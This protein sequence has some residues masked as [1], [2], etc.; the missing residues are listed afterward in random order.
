MFFLNSY[1]FMFMFCNIFYYVVYILLYLF[2]IA[3]FQNP[4]VHLEVLK[5]HF[6]L[7]LGFFVFHQNLFYNYGYAFSSFFF[8]SYFLFF[9]VTFFFGI[10]FI[11]ICFFLFIYR[12]LCK[13]GYDVC[14]LNNFC[15]YIASLLS[16]TSYFY[17]LTM[18]N[19]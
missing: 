13:L 15:S 9:F 18:D 4:H 1:F 5:V 3:S 17:F 2:N 12:D 6:I 7:E 14:Q 19:E 11:I 8:P 10:L 16:F